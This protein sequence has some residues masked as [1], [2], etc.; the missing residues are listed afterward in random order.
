MSVEFLRVFDPRRNMH[1][2][3]F[4]GRAATTTMHDAS[5]SGLSLSGIFQA[6]EDFA[7]LCLY[8]AYNYFNHLRVK[9][10][11]R[12]DPSGLRLAFDIEYVH[13]LDGATRFDAPKYPSVS[14]D[15]ITFVTGAGDV[16]EVPI[17]AHATIISGSE[18]PAN[19]QLDLSAEAHGREGPV[20]PKRPPACRGRLPRRLK[21]SACGLAGLRSSRPQHAHS[22]PPGSTGSGPLFRRSGGSLSIRP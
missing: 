1:V 19:L 13:A 21:R 17:L 22:S 11:P 3:G 2:Q 4:S 9:H 14:W 8:N 18:T 10:L 15:A 12:A 7:V 20:V 5:E 16:H 6:A